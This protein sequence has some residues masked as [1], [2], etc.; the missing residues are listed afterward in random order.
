MIVRL[1][2]AVEDDGN[3]RINCAAPSVPKVRTGIK[4]QAIDSELRVLR[5]M[6]ATP[7]GIRSARVN[8]GPC[9]PVSPV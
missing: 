7:V 2:I 1:T 3:F 9:V 8:S 5:E 4:C 6:P